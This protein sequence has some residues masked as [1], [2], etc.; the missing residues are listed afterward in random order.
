MSPLRRLRNVFSFVS[1]GPSARRKR[2]LPNVAD[3]EVLEHRQM[4]SATT[5]DT[6]VMN[7]E[8]QTLD[9]SGNIPVS[10][11]SVGE[12]F[13]IR[14]MAKD[15]RDAGAGVIS[16]YADV[17]FDTSKIDVASTIS[18][19]RGAAATSGLVDDSNGTV[20]EVGSLTFPARREFV[21]AEFSAVA[22]ELGTLTIST[23]EPENLRS[24]NTLLGRVE[25]VRDSTRYGA[26]SI[27][28]VEPPAP[29]DVTGDGEF[30]FSDDGIVLLAYLF[31]SRGDDLGSHLPPNS[32]PVAAVQAAIE[33]NRTKLDVD[34]DGEL[35]FATDG[36]ILL[37]HSRGGQLEQHRS[38]VSELDGAEIEN[39]VT[40]IMPT[41]N[42]RAAN[43]VPGAASAGT[44]STLAPRQTSVAVYDDSVRRDHE[45]ADALDNDSPGASAATFDVTNNDVYFTELQRRDSI[46]TEGDPRHIDPSAP[47]N[48][49]VIGASG[50]LA[51]GDATSPSERERSKSADP[52]NSKQ[53]GGVA[54]VEEAFGD[55]MLSRVL[56]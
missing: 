53:L 37:A 3:A 45:P 54:V 27:Q 28:V 30:D 38:Q 20:D 41:P 12:R 16:A 36:V 48:D 55:P 50:G 44:A 35:V 47:S 5:G 52:E 26:V 1:L 51:A 9:E 32:K 31:G 29:A 23:D 17:E 34:G 22:T 24:Q 39:R 19:E 10:Q 56:P 6:S 4:L 18:F 33:A 42:A 8:V 40:A 2:N 49:A 13:T 14:L 46:G 15:V 43:Q 11:V 7:I 25:D 21:M